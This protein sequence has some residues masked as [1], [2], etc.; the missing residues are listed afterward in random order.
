MSGNIGAFGPD[1]SIKIG[2]DPYWSVSMV[3]SYRLACG[4][5]QQ[6]PYGCPDG[7]VALLGV[8]KDFFPSAFENGVTAHCVHLK[9]DP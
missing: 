9:R 6:G 5:D 2:P 7:M 4:D 1:E 8:T 3:A